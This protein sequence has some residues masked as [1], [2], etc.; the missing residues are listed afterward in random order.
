MDNSEPKMVLI[1][2]FEKMNEWELKYYNRQVAVS[3]YEYNK[4]LRRKEVSDIFSTFLIKKESTHG[5]LISLSASE[6]PEY[7]PDESILSDEV[8][9]NKAVI[10]TQEQHG[11]KHKNR[12]SLIY[13]N[14]EWRIDEK[15]WFDDRVWL[16]RHF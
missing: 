11:F 14:N 1:N 4:E 6:P 13:K 5:R 15:E 7:S 12:Y 9:G 8:Q 10:I 2:F 3:D 16:T